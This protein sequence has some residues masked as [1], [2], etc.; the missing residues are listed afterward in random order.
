MVYC[1]DLRVPKVL[2][3]PEGLNVETLDFSVHGRCAN[4][5]Q[6]EVKR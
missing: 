2:R 3:V 4:C 5:T 1:L 6:P